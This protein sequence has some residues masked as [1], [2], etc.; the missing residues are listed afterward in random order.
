MAAQ[1]LQ[2]L[3]TST[4]LVYL[5]LSVKVC[6]ADSGLHGLFLFQLFFNMSV[7]I[8]IFLQTIAHFFR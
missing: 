6:L 5:I 3:K 4:K 1:M 7:I 8:I 2:D